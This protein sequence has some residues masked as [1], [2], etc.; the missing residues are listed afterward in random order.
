MIAFIICVLGYFLGFL[1]N[2][3][4]ALEAFYCAAN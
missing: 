4:K 3:F 2:L 1:S